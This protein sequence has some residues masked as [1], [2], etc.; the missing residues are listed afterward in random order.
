M[1]N[2]SNLKEC[3]P[4]STVNEEN[5]NIN[6]TENEHLPH[7]ISSNNLNIPPVNQESLDACSVVLQLQLDFKKGERQ[8]DRVEL[9]KV[10]INGT[11]FTDDRKSSQKTSHD[12]EHVG[13]NISSECNIQPN[14]HRKRNEDWDKYGKY[15]LFRALHTREFPLVFCGGG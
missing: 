10:T 4:E 7:V 15:I 3:D 6:C 8:L 11:N 2:K 5:V 14:N 13:L 9:T 12:L 1:T